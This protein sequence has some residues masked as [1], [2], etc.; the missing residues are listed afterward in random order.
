MASRFWVIVKNFPYF[1]VIKKFTCIIFLE[2]LQF[3][4]TYLFINDLEFLLVYGMK[5]GPIHPS[6]TTPW[7]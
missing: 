3:N 5:D 6:M 1:K 4:F 2:F 7:S